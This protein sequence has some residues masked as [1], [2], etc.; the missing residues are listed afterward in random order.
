M[1]ED[2]TTKTYLTTERDL[3]AAWGGEYLDLTQLLDEPGIR[4]P[5]PVDGKLE[6]E[7]ELLEDVRRDDGSQT[8]ILRFRQPIGDD[9]IYAGERHPNPVAMQMAMAEICTELSWSSIRSLGSK[10]LSRLLKVAS[11][12][13]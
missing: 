5:V 7:I 9:L 10:S 3:L 11:L 6:I 1:T 8:R 2:N 12:F 4:F 13:F